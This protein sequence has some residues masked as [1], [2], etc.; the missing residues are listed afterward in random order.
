MDEVRKACASVWELVCH[1]TIGQNVEP[2]EHNAN[3]IGYV[4]FNMDGDKDYQS[5]ANLLH[6]NQFVEVK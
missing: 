5:V 1:A 6:R 3:L 2:L 4:L